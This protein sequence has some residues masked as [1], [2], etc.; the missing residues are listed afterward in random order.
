VSRAGRRALAACAAICAAQGLLL[1][2][3]PAAAVVPAADRI[4]KATATANSASSRDQAL[5]LD[6]TLRVADREPIGTGQLVT[7]PSGLAR[8]ELRDAAGRIERHLRVVTEHSASRNGEE[9]ETPRD[10]L[11]PLSFLQVDSA[12]TL[13]QALTDYGLDASAAALAP[14]GKSICFVIGDPR[15]VPPP[16]PEP[17]ET[18][19]DNRKKDATAPA[20]PAF[21]FDAGSP[22]RVHPSLWVDSR[23]FEIVRMEGV[24]GARVDFGQAVDFD[25]VRF[26]GSITIH[27]PEREPVRFDILGITVVNAPAASFRRNWLLTPPQPGEETAPGAPAAQKAAR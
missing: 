18:G 26:P 21:D 16:P 13:Q 10:F 2:A 1:G 20:L 23:S 11:P 15:R 3:L 14:C 19:A 12:D 5:Q 9:L 25:G 27:E 22:D 4:A 17:E 7:H 6:L 24:G 8:L